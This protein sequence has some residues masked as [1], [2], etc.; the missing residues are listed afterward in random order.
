M[1]GEFWIKNGTLYTWND[2]TRRIQ[3]KIIATQ[4][5][6]AD[7]NSSINKWVIVQEN[8]SICSLGR[9]NIPDRWYGKDGVRVRWNGTGIQV[10]CRDG[11]TRIHDE[12]GFVVRHF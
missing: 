1:N 7:W 9:L 10:Q 6:D 5:I 11:R 3:E 8:G 12:R 2:P 4:V